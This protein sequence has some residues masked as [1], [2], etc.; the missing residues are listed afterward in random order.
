[1]NTEMAVPLKVQYLTNFWLN[2]EMV[3]INCGVNIILTYSENCLTCK[4]D[5][6]II[7]TITDTKL[8]LPVVTLSTQNTIKW[9]KY[10]SKFS[11]QA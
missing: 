8:Y 5:N 10:Q 11:T 9:E 2:L 7:L 1:M 3:L 4:E 6:V